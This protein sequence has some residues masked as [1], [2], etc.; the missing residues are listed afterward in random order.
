M[1][2][3][4]CGIV[5]GKVRDYVLWEDN[6]FLLLLDINPRNPGHSLL[7][8][9]KH[10]DYFF[11]LDKDLY[12]ELF[13]TAKRLERPLRKAMNAK[14]IGI[15]VV[16]FEVKHAHLHLVPLHSSNEMF[17]PL[18]LTKANAEELKVIQKKIKK[19]LRYF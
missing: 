16:G 5:N 1:N 3:K 14:R 8:P 12:N 10:I 13:L 11:D 9:K 4:F 18:K 15:A 17:D 2:C 19:H 6:K 7:I